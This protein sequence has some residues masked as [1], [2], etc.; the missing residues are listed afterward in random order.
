[1]GRVIDAALYTSRGPSRDDG[2][3]P[4]QATATQQRSRGSGVRRVTGSCGAWVKLA[5]FLRLDRLTS[6]VRESGVGNATSIPY[7]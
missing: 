4:V 2:V 3:A 7:R 6:P 1:M 5:R